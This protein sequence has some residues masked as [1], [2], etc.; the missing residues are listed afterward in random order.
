MGGAAEGTDPADLHAWLRGEVARLL[1]G[2][3]A[4]LMAIL[5][6]VDVREKDLAAA[7]AHDDVPGALA[8][9]LITRMDEKLRYRNG[10]DRAA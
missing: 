10:V 6:R 4:R 7:F 2:E 3:R 1:H 5:Y 8:D 9:A